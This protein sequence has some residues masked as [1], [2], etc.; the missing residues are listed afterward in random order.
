[1]VAPIQGD[2][3]GGL[4]LEDAKIPMQLEQSDGSN[5]TSA[6]ASVE[7]S[8][9]H[10]NLESSAVI[11]SQARR[12][13]I[14]NAADNDLGNDYPWYDKDPEF[15]AFFIMDSVTAVEVYFTFGHY[16]Q[17]HFG[18][19]IDDGS[20]FITSDD[21]TTT[22][23]SDTGFDLSANTWYRIRVKLNSGNNIEVWVDDD[24]KGTK[25]TNLPAGG[26]EGS[27]RT[28]ATYRL[29]TTE[30]VQKNVKFHDMRYMFTP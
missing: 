26:V 15:E 18:V 17:E 2:G 20:L 16:T 28:L 23:T 21:E 30:G 12:F 27:V 25:S 5:S 29:E 7:S 13:F 1:M 9:F 24:S 4:N 3:G 8:G 19:F 14:Q 6:D 10:I 11:N 22:S